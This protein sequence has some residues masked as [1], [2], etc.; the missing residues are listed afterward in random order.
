M[1]LPPEK[2]GMLS[3]HLHLRRFESKINPLGQ[4]RHLFE[5]ASKN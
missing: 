4:D 5:A 2:Y 1:H 3:G